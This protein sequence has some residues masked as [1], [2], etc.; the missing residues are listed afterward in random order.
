MYLPKLLRLSKLHNFVLLVTFTLLTLCL[1][2]SAYYLLAPTASAQVPDPYVPCEDTDSPEFQTLRPYQASP[3]NEPPGSEPISPLALFCG[4]DLFITD[5]ITVFRNNAVNCTMI[6]P[7]QEACFYRV[8][9]N[10]DLAIDV[11]NAHLPIMG[12][13]EGDVVNSRNQNETRNDAEKVNEYVSW[14]LAGVNIAAE[15]GDLDA[16][17][18]DDISKLVNF[19]GP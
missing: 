11:S 7:N 15:Y 9:R 13:T 3:C 2:L 17:N 5:T 4:N 14:H 1:L 12:R 18:E 19:S 6:S 16:G 10:L 8:R